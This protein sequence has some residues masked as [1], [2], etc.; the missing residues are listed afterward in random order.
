MSLTFKEF[1]GKLTK[2][3]KEMLNGRG[4]D[5]EYFDNKLK[6]WLSDFQNYS[7]YEP[8]KIRELKPIADDMKNLQKYIASMEDLFD[9]NKIEKFTE[10]DWEDTKEHARKL[11][12]LINKPGFLEIV[13]DQN[14]VHLSRYVTSDLDKLNKI[15]DL[16]VDT[17][18]ILNTVKK[19]EKRAQ[20]WLDNYDEIKEAEQRED[21]YKDREIFDE[22]GWSDVEEFKG[23]ASIKDHFYSKRT[24]EQK[25][26]DYKRHLGYISPGELGKE[27]DETEF[28]VNQAEKFRDSANNVIN[29]IKSM[30]RNISDSVI[31]QYSYSTE[32]ADMMKAFDEVRKITTKTV[33]DENNKDVD[34]RVYKPGDLHKAVKNV[35]EAID[36]YSKYIKKCDNR[37]PPSYGQQE[38]ANYIFDCWEKVFDAEEELRSNLKGLNN[39][40]LEQ[41]LDRETKKLDVINEVI[42]SRKLTPEDIEADKRAHVFEETQ[43]TLDDIISHG[44]KTNTK[45]R[46]GSQQFN[47]ALES[48]EDYFNSLREYNYILRSYGVKASEKAEASAKLMEQ[49]K[50]SKELI[51]KYFERKNKEL[52]NNSNSKERIALMKE[53]L[54]QIEIADK[55][56]TAENKIEQEKADKMPL[57]ERERA[58]PKRIAKYR[59]ESENYRK[60]RQE[61]D[62]R[63]EDFKN[64]FIGTVRENA[65]TAAADS[66]EQL[67]KL[68]DSNEPL[69]DKQKKDALEHIARVFT[70]DNNLLPQECDISMDDYLESVRPL[71][72]SK[73]FA[74]KVGEITP[75]RLKN[76]C[77]NPGEIISIQSA[78][79]EPKTKE[80]LSQEI[81]TINDRLKAYDKTKKDI[82]K[83]EEE[84]DLKRPS[85][86]FMDIGEAD[87]RPKANNEAPASMTTSEQ[88]KWNETVRKRNIEYAEMEERRLQQ[89]AEKRRNEE[90]A[91]AEREK[92][93]AERIRAEKAEKKARIKEKTEKQDFKRPQNTPKLKKI[94]DPDADANSLTREELERHSR[95]DPYYRKI[96]VAKDNKS[97]DS[98][99]PNV[100][101][102]KD[103][104]D[105]EVKPAA[106]K[107][108]VIGR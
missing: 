53:A 21:V 52:W 32:Y 69:T 44:R 107:P 88:I 54:K 37:N 20:D 6:K 101:S 93:E 23:E 73:V 99:R 17:D 61:Q 33:K 39:S 64:R 42:E 15:F 92:A 90:I 72:K 98:K 83:R 60:A 45:V 22:L 96:L 76:I 94:K 71:S 48:V 41:Q 105:P 7:E 43:Y 30:T 59:E 51:N 55:Q 102:L 25:M 9:V 58:I 47:N 18:M 67:C 80:R 70:Y 62:I 38:Y 1:K 97:F 82:K 79:S 104:S 34:E 95:R 91:K 29:A 108:K 56:M 57:R 2:E 49:A 68:A 103:V 75:E 27:K 3:N 65:A 84:L 40:D 100:P 14:K 50:K 12:E 26:N 24:D 36:K 5:I 77:K 31:R 13:L 63:P 85:K 74:E 35:E 28:I 46:N 87:V 81:K 19:R 4:E 8:E 106:K 11:N 16:G 10:K 78:L 89:L 86:D 66:I